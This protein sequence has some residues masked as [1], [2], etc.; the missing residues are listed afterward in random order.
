M[1]TAPGLV[2]V[3]YDELLDDDNA[4]EKLVEAVRSERV[5]PAPPPLTLLS[6]PLPA[7]AASGG[8]LAVDGWVGD[9][10]WEGVL[11]RGK[12]KRN[13]PSWVIT[14]P[15]GEVTVWTDAGGGG[16]GGA[17][18]AAGASAPDGAEGRAEHTARPGLRWH[19]AAGEWHWRTA[20]QGGAC[21]R[22]LNSEDAVGGG[23]EAAVEAAAAAEEEEEDAADRPVPRRKRMRAMKDGPF[24]PSPHVDR[25]GHPLISPSLL[26]ALTLT[27]AMLRAMLVDPAAAMA[28]VEGCFSRSPLVPPLSSAPPDEPGLW[29]VHACECLS[30]AP[31]PQPRSAEALAAARLLPA[32]APAERSVPGDALCPGPPSAAVALHFLTSVACVKVTMERAARVVRRR[33]AAAGGSESEADAA[34]AAACVPHTAAAQA[35][36]VAAWMEHPTAPAW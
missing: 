20:A 7:A 14:Y 26:R 36:V 11:R 3:R 21:G 10:W 32:G 27:P 4:A 33:V 35:A 34:V 19:A 28:C 12:S 13:E 30:P 6:L 24:P 1:S 17:G 5:R 29:A 8:G 15:S 18:G 2:T 16:G 23:E 31:P 25:P 22:V 9:L